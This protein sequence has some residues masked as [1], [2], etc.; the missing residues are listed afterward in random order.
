MDSKE[1]TLDIVFGA[2]FKIGF[3]FVLAGILVF[4]M[5]LFEN[6]VSPAL[7]K[8]GFENTL[9]ASPMWLKV[10]ITAVLLV[11]A[12]LAVHIIRDLVELVVHKLLG[13]D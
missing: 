9:N 11:G 2:G 5:Q 1:G 8:L 10:V 13:R 6:V 4:Y 3:L 7:S 12:A